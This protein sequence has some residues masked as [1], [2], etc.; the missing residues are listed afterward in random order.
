MTTRAPRPGTQGILSPRGLFDMER[1]VL[2]HEGHRVE[3]TQPYGCPRN[4]TMG[5]MYVNCVTCT[6]GERPFFIG[7]VLISSFVR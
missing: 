6:E 1:R 2:D 5:H 4:G 3:V 7:L